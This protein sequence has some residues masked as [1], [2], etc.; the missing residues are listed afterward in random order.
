LDDGIGVKNSGIARDV[1]LL[2]YEHGGD[3]L[4][5]AV[6]SARTRY[7]GPTVRLVLERLIAAKAI[8]PTARRGKTQ[9]YGLTP[10]GIAG[11]DA[12][13]AA[14]VNFAEGG[15]RPTLS[16]AASPRPAG[17]LPSAP[18]PLPARYAA[19]QPARAA[20]E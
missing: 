10:R 5:V 9:L 18:P 6:I 11:C 13:V 20:A 14:L 17:G 12:Y 15:M 4:S 2:L 8:A 19:A 1:V 16:V 3:G 7:S